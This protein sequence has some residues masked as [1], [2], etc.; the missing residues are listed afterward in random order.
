[1]GGEKAARRTV[2]IVDDDSSIRH[3][4]TLLFRHENFDVVGEAMNGQQAIA[5][6]R[7]YQPDF[8]IL[9]YLMPTINGA[10]AANAL[11]LLAPASR[12]V[13]FSAALEEQ[14]DWADAFL[15][16]DRIVEMTPLLE[17]LCA[18]RV[19]P[20]EPLRKTS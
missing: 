7:E 18:E 5:L 9:D 17:S 20:R 19:A 14:P 10:S 15:N 1:M 6:A 11:R 16:K 12:I 3:V 2:V 8:I 4:L 13:A